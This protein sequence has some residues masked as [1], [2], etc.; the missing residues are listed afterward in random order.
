MRD[1]TGTSATALTTGGRARTGRMLTWLSVRGPAGVGALALLGALLAFAI[2]Y[3][4]YP[5]PKRSHRFTESGP[6]FLWLVI[7][8]GQVALWFALTPTIA[9]TLIRYG[10][11]WPRA[12]RQ[13]VGVAAALFL[14]VVLPLLLGQQL[15]GTP[16]YPLP[17]RST[18][19]LVITLIGV[20]VAVLASAAIT[21]IMSA[22]AA[23]TEPSGKPAAGELDRFFE[24]RTTLTRVLAIEGAILG[25]AILA[26]G[27]LRHAVVATRG[28]RAFPQET[29]LAYGG[30]L[31]AILALLYIPAYARVLELGRQL[32]NRIAPLDPSQ[33]AAI[34]TLEQRAKLTELLDLDVNASTSFRTSV[35]ILT[36]L[37]S[38]LLGLLIGKT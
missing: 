14:L 7:V 18:K 5:F 38:S 23:A 16:K 36:P 30:Y 13:V 6:Y 32:R 3:L 37:T 24:L 25:A 17:Y 8:C 15:H 34:D 20:A 9:Q 21:L 29:L 2:L 12:R 19:I 27:A 35:L 33:T 28:E 22:I 4:D 1:L 26:T 11:H 31:S 10:E